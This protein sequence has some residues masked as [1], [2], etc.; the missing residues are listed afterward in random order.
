MDIFF[1]Y[2]NACQDTN[3]MIKICQ[4]FNTVLT[5]ALRAKMFLDGIVMYNQ[6][7]P[8]LH[9]PHKIKPYSTL[10]KSGTCLAVIKLLSQVP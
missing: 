4:C 8:F 3:M 10:S 9:F 6:H 7:S 5:E 1:N 2:K